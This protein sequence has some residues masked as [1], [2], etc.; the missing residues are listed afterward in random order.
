MR[1]GTMPSTGN[2]TNGISA[3]TDNGIA[4]VIHHEAI[5]SAT[6]RA[7]ETSGFSGSRSVK[8]YTITNKMIPVNNP[9][10]FLRDIRVVGSKFKQYPTR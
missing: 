4:S 7:G 1:P 9:M 3:V 2:S 5:R 8:K 6:A 10:V